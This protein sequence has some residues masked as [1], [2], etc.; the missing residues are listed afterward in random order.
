MTDIKSDNS[1]IFFDTS[2]GFGSLKKVT[3]RYGSPCNLNQAFPYLTVLTLS[4]SIMGKP[5]PL[6]L[7]EA[8]IPEA[9]TRNFKLISI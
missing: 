5:S 9:M 7:H 3:L 6:A 1:E 2:E 4:I 8:S